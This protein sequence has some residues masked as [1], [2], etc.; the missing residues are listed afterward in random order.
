[1]L[2][3]ALATRKEG[4]RGNDSVEVRKSDYLSY[5]YKAGA[6]WMCLKAI[7]SLVGVL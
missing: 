6:K 1:M 2:P 4:V 7:I 5:L 3:V